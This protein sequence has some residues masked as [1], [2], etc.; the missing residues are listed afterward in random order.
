MHSFKPPPPQQQNETVT[1]YNAMENVYKTTN[2]K[3]ILKLNTR[4]RN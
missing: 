2:T 3:A 4:L 1:V